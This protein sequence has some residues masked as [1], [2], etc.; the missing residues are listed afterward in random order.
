MTERFLVVL[1]SRDP[2]LSVVALRRALKHLWRSYGLRAVSCRRE[3]PAP[4]STRQSPGRRKP[5]RRA[6]LV[7]LSLPHPRGAPPGGRLGETGGF[8][9]QRSEPGKGDS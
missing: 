4:A 7:T 5:A 8:P 6:S 2:A 3:N 9:A 1:E